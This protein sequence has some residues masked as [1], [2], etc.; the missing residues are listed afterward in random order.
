[1]ILRLHQ[2]RSISRDFSGPAWATLAGAAASGLLYYLVRR[3]AVRLETIGEKLR[4]WLPQAART[5]IPA[6]P[7]VP[8]AGK[9]IAS[10]APLPG[11][12]DA[13]AAGTGSAPKARDWI[14]AVHEAME[15][16]PRDFGFDK[17]D[18]NAPLLGE[19][20]RKHHGESIPVNRIRDA[21]KQSGYQWQYSRYRKARE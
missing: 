15:R 1:M 21:L 20:L 13:S 17:P 12:P 11:M 2:T 19:Y 7:A 18:W 4:G 5:A 16:E 6:A 9:P 10:D 8:A 3:K 14:H